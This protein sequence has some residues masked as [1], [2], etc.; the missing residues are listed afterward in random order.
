MYRD[1]HIQHPHDPAPYVPGSP[2]RFRWPDPHD[3]DVEAIRRGVQEEGRG[4][5]VLLAPWGDGK[6]LV[7]A[8]Y[9]EGVRDLFASTRLDPFR[10]TDLQEGRLVVVGIPRLRETIKVGK[11]LGSFR[12]MSPAGVT[13]TMLEEI[14]ENNR[15]ARAHLRRNAP[16]SYLKQEI[17]DAIAAREQEAYDRWADFY[18]DA[19][20]QTRKFAMPEKR[21]NFYI[22]GG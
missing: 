14:R 11:G 2:N 19:W 20:L 3:P 8:Y 18:Y 5:Y 22:P 1:P 12:V 13:A 16:A 7:E 10:K 15:N 4:L 17:N 21:Q 6:C 9:P